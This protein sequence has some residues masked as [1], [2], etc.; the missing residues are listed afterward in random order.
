MRVMISQPMK[1]LSVEEIRERRATVVAMLGADGHEAVDTVKEVTGMDTQERYTDNTIPSMGE[2][3]TL[4]DYETFFRKLVRE[5]APNVFW[6]TMKGRPIMEVVANLIDESAEILKREGRHQGRCEICGT[7][8][9]DTNYGNVC[10]EIISVDDRESGEHF[11]FSGVLHL[12]CREHYEPG[13]K[14]E[15]R[16]EHLGFDDLT[17]LLC[18]YEYLKRNPHKTRVRQHLIAAMKN[19]IA[20]LEKMDKG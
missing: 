1:G 19:C 20:G 4:E 6:E 7:P 13:L 5:C 15:V 16:K 10:R 9:D 2:L 14:F 8:I 18:Y 3:R 11:G 17:H 12:R